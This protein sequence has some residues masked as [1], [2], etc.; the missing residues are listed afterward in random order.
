MKK[1]EAPETQLSNELCLDFLIQAGSILH[2]SDELRFKLN[3]VFTQLRELF[4]IRNAMVLLRDDTTCNCRIAVAPELTEEDQKEANKLIEN[5]L[6]WYLQRFEYPLI[7]YAS[8]I[9]KLPLFYSKD[10][11][12]H[13]VAFASYPITKHG[14]NR[15]IGL[16]LGYVTRNT[17]MQEQL[18]LLR[19]LAD[20]IGPS[21]ENNNSQLPKSQELQSIPMVLEGIV[22]QSDGLREIAETIKKVALSRASVLLTGESGTGK[23]VIARSIHQYSL[24]SWAPFIGVNCAALTETL[25]GSELFGHE[26]G[27]Y[28]GA[29]STKKGRFEL[30]SGGTL[31][32]D[33]ISNTSQDFQAKLLRILQEKEFERLGGVKTIKTDVRVICATNV[34]LRKLIQEGRFRED[35]YYRLNV[36]PLNIPPLRERKEDIPFLV[37][38][39][40]M[41]LN[42]EYK[43]FLIISEEDIS[44]LQEY[45]WPGNIRE[46]ENIIHRAFLMAQG[47]TLQLKSILQVL[48]SRKEPVSQEISRNDTSRTLAENN[49]RSKLE[50]EEIQ[51]IEKALT[52]TKGVQLKAA[53][54]L[55]IS[56]RQLRY[57]IQKYNLEV[58]KIHY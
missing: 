2:S 24:R 1:I 42:Q 18:K 50:H 41:K 46:L 30:A 14:K 56:M 31:F 16:L 21:L 39:F 13:L 44:L 54:L 57:R 11:K 37:N 29:V 27:A 55:G 58:R 38:Y 28:T 36:I 12:N 51:A 8:D 17:L 32:L 34:D 52:A 20:L 19:I 4:S 49:Y 10:L 26:K 23:E 25:L 45:P 7:L 40:L 6:D 5:N 33:E 15:P 9:G 47:Q 53:K 3:N 48:S 43:K 35:L 22:G